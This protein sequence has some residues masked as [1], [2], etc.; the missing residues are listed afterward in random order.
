MRSKEPVGIAAAMAAAPDRAANPH[1]ESLVLAGEIASFG[2]RAAHE[3]ALQVEAEQAPAAEP[4]VT[5]SR[6]ATFR[7]RTA[8]LARFAVTTAQQRRALLAALLGVALL[9]ASVGVLAGRWLAAR[10]TAAA[11]AT[12]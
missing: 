2:E 9:S 8:N 5:P 10:T 7:T 4:E 3:P 11:R 1:D 12:R 6:A